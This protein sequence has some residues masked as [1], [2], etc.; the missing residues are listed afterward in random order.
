MT[1]PTD[2]DVQPD[3]G[4]DPDAADAQRTHAEDPAEG[5]GADGPDTPR[6]HSEDP[7]EG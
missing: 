3:P 7:A 5:E 6:E 4:T 2:G 1:T